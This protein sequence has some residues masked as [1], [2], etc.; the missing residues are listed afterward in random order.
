MASVLTR[1]LRTSNDP[2]WIRLRECIRQ[3]GYEPCD[4][5]LPQFFPDGGNLE[6]GLLVA[7]DDRVFEFDLVYGVGDLVA[8]QASA[9]IRNWTETSDRWRDQPFRGEVE[10]ELTWLAD[11]EPRD[12]SPAWDE[13]TRSGY[14]EVWDE[15][16]RRF[17][18]RPNFYDDGGSGF[19][20]PTPSIAWSLGSTFGA[21]S[22]MF[23]FG[24]N[25]LN[26][27]GLAV[28]QEL[29][30]RNET[31]LALDWQHPAYR[32]APHHLLEPSERDQWAIPVFPNGDYYVFLERDFEWGFFGHPW[33]QTWCVF[34]QRALDAIEPFRTWVLATEA[35]RDGR[36][37]AGG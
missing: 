31:V 24:A 2:L 33:R 1:L 29:V 11:E 30:G 36:S 18:F 32:F 26:G 3:R 4:C 21:E 34:G 17:E 14:D 12:D 15:F 6:F 5:A 27:I 28:L 7:P 25:A 22:R 19:L 35:R 37:I 20:E 16:D 13:L 23:E 8:Q 9:E 10:Q